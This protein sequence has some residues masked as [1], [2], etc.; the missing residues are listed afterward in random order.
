[1]CVIGAQG[2]VFLKKK[3]GIY[4]EVIVRGESRE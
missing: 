4:L 1:M 3:K 2:Q